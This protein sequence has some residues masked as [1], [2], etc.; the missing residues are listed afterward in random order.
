MQDA[1]AKSDVL[2]DLV[3]KEVSLDAWLGESATA[4]LVKGSL[5]TAK[6]ET[7]VK[8]SPRYRKTAGGIDRDVV[9]VVR[10]LVVVDRSWI[11]VR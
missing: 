3:E 6:G 8:L 1:K 5:G 9:T 2:Q 10:Y 7:I 11:D 4:R